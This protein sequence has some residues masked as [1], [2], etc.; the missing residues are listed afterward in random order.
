MEV[1]FMTFKDFDRAASAA[2]TF[3]K[4]RV[5]DGNWVVTRFQGDQL[6]I[7]QSNP[8][9]GGLVRCGDRFPLTETI[10]YRMV[11]SGHPIVAPNI[12]EHPLLV[13]A[14]V[15]RSLGLQSYLGVP[16]TTDGGGVF[17]TVCGFST[18]QQNQSLFGEQPLLEL[19]GKLLSTILA[20]ELAAA[21]AAREVEHRTAQALRDEFSGV[22]NRRGLDE[23]IVAEEH[24][25]KRYG[26]P[27]CALVIDL[28]GLKAINDTQGH[29]AGDQLIARAAD[30]L[31]CVSRE[32][33]IVARTG[34]DEFILI[35]VECNEAG[36]E[37]MV[38][39]VRDRLR[40]G[41]VSAAIGMSFRDS[42]STLQ[43]AIERADALM[44]EDKRQFK[45]ARVS[46]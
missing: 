29:K 28:N 21:N 24:R 18:E 32:C 8:S 31:D 2:L 39:R 23:L 20:Q 3:L 13:D 43:Q 17:G 10:C 38:Q 30:A 4:S 33:D 27:A 44:Y 46:A 26:H 34:G 25:C 22:Y 19:I 6:L 9:D 5:P 7:L 16:L 36:G 1:P 35:A 15:P 40:Q 11:Q 41:G 37:R 45:S 12:A 14:T 42:N